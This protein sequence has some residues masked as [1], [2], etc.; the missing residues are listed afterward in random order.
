MALGL[1]V[2]AQ[3]VVMLDTSIVNVALPSIQAD[4][5]LGPTGVT[6]VVNAYVLAFGSLLLLSGR[7]ADLFGRRRMFVAGS[8]L[9]TAGTLLAAAAA[10]PAMLMA[11]RIIQGAG[12]AALSPAAMSLL[13]LTFPGPERARA[14]SIW[15]AASG[16][17]GATGVFAGGLLAGTFG[18]SSVFLVTV[19]VSVT[20]VVLARHVLPKSGR[21]VPGAGSTGP[22]QR[23]S[24]AR[25]SPWSTALS[26]SPRTAG[27]PRPSS[28]ASPAPRCCSRPSCTSSAAPPTRWCRSSSSGPGR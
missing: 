27:P 26:A 8:A 13:L 18:W 10:N 24:P 6:W 16:L 17:G 4:L 21:T 28:P 7:A 14:M 3:F 1:L 11:G 2:S 23:P 5:G 20:A 9:F 12:A 25:S 19:P 15:G 22:A